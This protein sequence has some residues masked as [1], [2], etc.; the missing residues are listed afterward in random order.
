ML[1][2]PT[3]NLNIVVVISMERFGLKRVMLSQSKS[4]MERFASGF[5]RNTN[6]AFIKCF[7]SCN[8]YVMLV[9]PA[10]NLNIVLVISVERFG[11]KRVM[12][13]LLKHP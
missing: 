7:T 9:I 11:L 2:I 1:V 8:F 5:M 6:L 13:S 4:I 12:L 3:G 10:G